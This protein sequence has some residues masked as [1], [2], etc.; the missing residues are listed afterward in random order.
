LGTDHETEERTRDVGD[1]VSFLRLIETA[2][3]LSATV[4]L[5]IAIWYLFSGRIPTPR[6][7]QTALDEIKRERERADR[8]EKQAENAHKRLTI[9]TETLPRMAELIPET[10][11]PRIRWPWERS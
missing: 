5:V 6:E 2:G 11:R 4:L 9:L 10:D 7:Y 1:A 8:L 3:N